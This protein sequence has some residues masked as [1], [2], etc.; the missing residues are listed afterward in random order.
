MRIV[1]TGGAGYIGSHTVIELLGAGHDVCIIDNFSNSQKSALI[2]IAD[3]SKKPFAHA[4]VDIR[5]RIALTNKLK[6]F[7]PD[8]VIH[9]AG[10]KAVGE[11][12]RTPL[13]YYDVNVSGTVCL[14]QAMESADC[15]RIVF[16]SSATVYG[17]PQYVP[18]DEKHPCNPTNPYGRTKF[19]AEHILKDWHAAHPSKSAVSLR[20]FNPVGAHAS[21]DLGE[22]PRGLPNNLMPLIAQTAAGICN[23]LSIFGNDYNTPDGTGIRDYIHVV[24]LARA[25]LAAVEH[26]RRHCDCLTLN[27]GTGT[28]YSVLEVLKAFKQ[29]SG[30]EVPHKFVKR[31]PGD[32]ARSV[33]D[34]TLAQNTLGWKAS[35]PLTLMCDSAW[36]WQS[37]IAGT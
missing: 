20:Y 15:Q 3:I 36:R 5:D 28:G 13:D 11:S 33:A 17:E 19:M 2:R 32:T 23:E 18:L 26:T 31:R 22:N 34:S 37:R 30:K 14:L 27:I 4:K 21:G 9:F 10:L 6:H 29:A 24:D 8:T 16:S 7:R 1:V 12:S 35:L 25:H